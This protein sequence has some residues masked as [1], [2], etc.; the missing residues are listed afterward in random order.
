MRGALA[1]PLGPRTA[2]ADCWPRG[3]DFL[4]SWWSLPDRARGAVDRARWWATAPPSTYDRAFVDAG[5]RRPLWRQFCALPPERPRD[6]GLGAHMR[7]IMEDIARV[8]RHAG[9]GHGGMCAHGAGVPAGVRRR[10]PRRLALTD[11]A[12]V[13]QMATPPIFCSRC[14]GS[15]CST[16]AC[17]VAGPGLID[18]AT[19]TASRHTGS[20]ARHRG[21]GDVGRPS[22]NVSRTWRCRPRVLATSPWLHQRMTRILHAAELA[23]E[24]VT[25]RASRRA[26]VRVVCA[27][28]AERRRALVT[29]IA[30]SKRAARG[31]VLTETVSPGPASAVPHQLAAERRQ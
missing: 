27:R 30:L 19:D 6:F 3:G 21:A 23:R 7:P 31:S 5:H 29:V 25:T 8:F 11:R 20:A 1:R 24:Y 16:P 15:W 28:A 9:A 12:G 2:A 14:W 4:G 22:R 17:W 18:I 13:G 10:A 26:R